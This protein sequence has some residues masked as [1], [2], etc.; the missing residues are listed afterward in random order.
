MAKPKGAASANSSFLGRPVG[1]NSEETRRRIL[2]ATMRCVAEFGYSRTT[3]REIAREAKMTSGSLYHYF[4]N[5]AELVRATFD[6]VATIAVPRL[7]QAAEENVA[8]LDKLMAVLDESVRVMRDYPL[9]VAFDRAIRAESP[10]HLHLAET[11]DRRFIALRNL[12][13]D[14]L[15]QGVDHKELGP[16]VDAESAANAVYMI[17]RGLNEYAASA[18]PAAEYHAT[19]AALKQLLRG[20]LFNY[21]VSR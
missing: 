1:A 8:T 2:E 9:A 20:Q 19:V 14:I 10:Q 11:S 15:E 18:P 5:K 16:G 12:I 21:G 13:R 6:E 3:I 4:P 7:E 17:F